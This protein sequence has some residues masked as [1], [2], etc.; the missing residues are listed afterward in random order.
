[1]DIIIKNKDNNY[2][3][4]NKNL[5]TAATNCNNSLCKHLNKIEVS[6]MIVK[7]G[8]HHANDVT[9]IYLSEIMPEKLHSYFKLPCKFNRN[10]ST[11]IVRRDSSEGEMDW[12]MNVKPDNQNIFEKILINVEFQTGPVGKEKI[13]IIADYRDYAKTYYDLPVLS[14]IVLIEGYYSSEHEY[15]RVE[16]DIIRPVYIFMDEKELNERLNNLLEKTN[17][18]E[19]LSDDEAL[20]MVFIPM[21]APKGKEKIITEKTTKLFHKDATLKGKFREN[22]AFA[23]S[24]MI[25]KYFKST[26]KEKELL[27]MLEGEIENT[28]LRRVIDFEVDHIRTSLEKEL[29]ESKKEN[30]YLKK[31]TEYLKAKL[32]ENGVE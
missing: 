25:Q 30:E 29:E 22:I 15:A 2:F 19:K 8:I 32:K 1:M 18:H 11:K 7:N 31:E 26:L 17:K 24:I 9:N 4:F 12:L 10:Y 5:N 14:I 16:S 20:D 27:K 3:I 21:F 6:N 28:R 23:L 13:K